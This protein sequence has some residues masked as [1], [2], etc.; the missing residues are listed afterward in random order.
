LPSNFKR[1]ILPITKGVLLGILSGALLGFLISIDAFN[2]WERLQFPQRVND[3][4]LASGHV[5]WVETTTSELYKL[6]DFCTGNCWEK[7]EKIPEDPE[8]LDEFLYLG[9]GIFSD[10]YLGDECNFEHFTYPLLVDKKVCV[11]T[12]LFGVE[13]GSWVY[14]VLDDAGSLWIWLSSQNMYTPSVYIFL[15][16]LFAFVGFFP[17]LILGW[18]LFVIQ[19]PTKNI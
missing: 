18:I 6:D 13:R 4:V 3:I 9:G 17:S 5:L 2:H 7:V 19:Q 11:K 12:T 14:V 10:S 1:A 8:E 16:I 15:P